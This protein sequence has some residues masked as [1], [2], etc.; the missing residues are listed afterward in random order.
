MEHHIL[1][2]TKEIGEVKI[3]IQSLI[4]G[5]STGSDFLPMSLFPLTICS[6]S[7][8]SLELLTTATTDVLQRLP[9]S[10]SFTLSTISEA[11]DVYRLHEGEVILQARGSLD[12]MGVA[13]SAL[14][15]AQTVASM[16]IETLNSAKSLEDV[17][18]SVLGKLELFARTADQI[19]V[20][21]LF[22]DN[23]LF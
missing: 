11:A 23:T 3:D 1:L 20:V 16:S 8:V 22:V 9:T 13:P 19:S 6:H 12:K 4:E 15:K 5:S 21:R 17:W 10:I 2:K 14:G 7:E 18:S